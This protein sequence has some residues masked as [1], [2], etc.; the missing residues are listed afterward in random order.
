M[1]YFTNPGELD[2]RLTQL[3]GVNVK[4]DSASPIG[5]FGTGLKYAIAVTLRLNGQITLHSGLSTYTFHTRPT[6]LRGKSFDLVYMH[7]AEGETQMPFT[8]ELGKAWEPWMAYRELWSNAKDEGG[9][10]STTPT[11][12]SAGHTVII[13]DCPSLE[14]A[15]RDRAT[16]LLESTP[17]ASSTEVEIHRSPSKSLFYRGIKVHEFEKPGCYTYNL[18]SHT[19]LTEDRTL[20]SPWYAK[21]EVLRGVVASG[22]QTI[23]GHLLLAGEGLWEWETDWDL[24]GGSLPPVFNEVVTRLATNHRSKLPRTILAHSKA[25]P[26]LPYTLTPVETK[27]LH[28]AKA[29]LAKLHYDVQAEI[30]VVESLGAGVLGSVQGEKILLCKE[31]FRQGT[32]RLAGTL[33]EEHLHVTLRVRDYDAEMQNLLID[34]IM[35]MGEELIGEPL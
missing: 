34:T 23:I 32:K 21:R 3:F 27:M 33:L 4:P 26:P 13:V 18:L 10:T 29:F 11:P 35:S 12:P 2:P 31:A 17:I 7:S 5:F 22:D 14:K 1:L 6:I 30:Q 20:Q 9:T 24:W 8:L 19:Q 28:K 25:L 15:H 16:F